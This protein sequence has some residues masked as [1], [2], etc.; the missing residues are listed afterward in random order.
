MK[1]IECE[2]CGYEYNNSK[3]KCPSCG[4][5]KKEKLFLFWIKMLVLFEI[6]STLTILVASVFN[7][8]ITNGKYGSDFIMEALW[9]LCILVIMIYRGKSYVFT[10]KKEKFWKAVSLGVPIIIISVLSFVSSLSSLDGINGLNLINLILFCTSIGIAEEFLCRG[11]LQNEFIERFGKD[12]KQVILSIIL[13][14]L[15][16]GFMHL[17][18]LWTLDQSLFETI[19][20]IAQTTFVGIL[21]G[22]IYYRTKNIWAVV[23][24]HSFYDFSIMLSEVNSLRDCTSG[25]PNSSIMLYK[26]FASLLLIS[27][28]AIFSFLL[29]RKTKLNKVIDENYEI[30]VDD[31][32][33]DAKKS[34]ISYILLVVLGIL[35]FLPIQPNTEDYESYNI[36]YNF[37]TKEINEFDVHFQNRFNYLI[38]DKQVGQYSFTLYYNESNYELILKNNKTNDNISFDYED[39]DEYEVI[40]NSDNY[41]ILISTSDGVNSTGYYKVI[42]KDGMSNSKDFLDNIKVSMEK[43]DLPLLYKIG[44][45]TTNDND[46][47]FPYMET[48]LGEKFII[49]E[50]G[51]LYLLEYFQN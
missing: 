7:L 25:I 30:S 35:F 37:N 29:L 46:Y 44:Y 38:S 12:R 1:L 24:L 33:S 21:F 51:K 15:I 41:I 13:S 31:E 5:S 3:K 2:K 9:A 17:S 43:Y 50:D 34:K 11:W 27:F 32:N 39:I 49:D 14:A 28:Y 45:L 10:E 4:N 20:Q 47:K 26:I 22:S 6:V 16:F 36:C 23:F 40:E 42:S 48:A 19:L 18:N 8:S